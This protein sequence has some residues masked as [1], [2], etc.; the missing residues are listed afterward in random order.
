VSDRCGLVEERLHR[1]K[2]ATVDLQMLKWRLLLLKS[3]MR[4][5]QLSIEDMGSRL[6]DNTVTLPRTMPFKLGAHNES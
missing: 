3:V 2:E 4:A 1:L 5:N 6:T